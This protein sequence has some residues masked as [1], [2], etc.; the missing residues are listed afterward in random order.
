MRSRL[1]NLRSL[2][3]VIHAL[4][5]ISNIAL[6]YADEE[7]GSAEAVV[8]ASGD[9][10]VEDNSEPAAETVESTPSSTEEEDT[11]AAAEEEEPAATDSAAVEEPASEEEKG[12]AFVS[13]VVSSAKDKATALVD[14][15]KSVTPAQMKKVAAGAL[16]I[17][18]VAAGAGWVMNNLGQEE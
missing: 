17:W 13:G 8:D 14:K 12:S 15:A 5:S 2:F 10:Q 9:V 7:G 4:L 18:G 3:V 1:M 11:P 16:G 6:V